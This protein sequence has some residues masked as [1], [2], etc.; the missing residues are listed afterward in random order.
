[1]AAQFAQLHTIMAI[2][3]EYDEYDEEV[4]LWHSPVDLDVVLEVWRLVSDGEL[5]ES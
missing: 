1:M 5:V 4:P 3:D 2:E